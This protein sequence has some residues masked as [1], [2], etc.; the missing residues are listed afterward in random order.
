MAGIYVH[1]PFCHSKCIYCDFFSTPNLTTSDA[2]IN[3]LIKE[4]GRRSTE[5]NEPIKTIYFGGGTPS[6]IAPERLARV[7]KIFPLSN[8]EEFTI[9]V[10]P[11]DVNQV[12][13]KAWR[14][15]GVN[16]VSM[17]IQSFCDD[18]LRS[19]GRR[20][21]A[22]DAR[23]AI[24]C[25]LDGGITNISC[26]LIYG[27]PGQGIESWRRSLSELLSY[28][29]PHISAYCLSYEPGTALY[30]RMTAGKITP[31]DDM[32][33]A[34]MYQYFCEAAADAGY[35]HYEISNFALPG[36]RSR[37][38]SSYWN[39]TPYLGLGPGAHSF[40]GSVRRFNTNDLK[41]Y[42]RTADITVIDEETADER[43]NDKLITA[44]RTADGLDLNTLT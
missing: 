26:D 34:E 25:L 19:I 3:A 20:H 24:K 9:E 1:I 40:D 8:I 41:T 21:S 15:I 37:H 38:N 10:N 43:F 29:L 4:Y 44:L 27:L 28:R 31:T 11:E 42:I 23:R 35:E 32:I 22:D 14:D 30:A 2:L 39:E 33:L 17:G 12:S 13:V 5:I 18:E 6:I 16:R 7:C 36:M